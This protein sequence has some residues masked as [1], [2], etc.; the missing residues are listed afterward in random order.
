MGIKKRSLYGGRSLYRGGLANRLDC[1]CVNTC[2]FLVFFSH[3][4]STIFNKLASVK[5][6]ICV[7]QDCPVLVTV[8]GCIRN[9]IEMKS[10]GADEEI[11]EAV[12]IDHEILI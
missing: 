1:T 3:C 6:Y 2:I 5:L 11:Q 4:C 12:L 7:R 8:H 10:F 9:D